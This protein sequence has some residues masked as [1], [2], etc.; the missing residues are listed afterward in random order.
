PEISG[1][2]PLASGRKAALA[3]AVSAPAA[4]SPSAFLA[5]GL[6]HAATPIVAT[7]AAATAVLQRML[8]SLCLNQTNVP[9]ALVSDH[10]WPTLD[11]KLL[12][13]GHL[14]LIRSLSRAHRT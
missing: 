12:P 6:P 8:F 13:A 7:A 2:G 4:L 5:D 9:H 11:D 10:R 3:L 1:A 14:P